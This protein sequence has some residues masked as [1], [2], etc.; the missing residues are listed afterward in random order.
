MM[1]LNVIYNR[2]FRLYGLS[3]VYLAP[4]DRSNIASSFFADPVAIHNAALENRL[5]VLDMSSSPIREIT[6]EYR[7]KD[8]N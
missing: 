2:P 6:A 7:K 1:Y 5:I 8:N 4:E 3:E